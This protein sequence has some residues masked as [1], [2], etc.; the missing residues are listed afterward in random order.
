MEISKIQE[1]I[2]KLNG[3]ELSVLNFY[4]QKRLDKE[5]LRYYNK[6]KKCELDYFDLLSILKNSQ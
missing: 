1:F 2:N 3:Y 6:Y 4:V 5:I